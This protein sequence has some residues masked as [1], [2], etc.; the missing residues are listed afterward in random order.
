MAWSLI[1]AWDTQK[2]DVTKDQAGSVQNQT[3]RLGG[4]T[5]LAPDEDIDGYCLNTLRRKPFGRWYPRR[6]VPE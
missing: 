5:H 6:T 3:T 2:Q 1:C 4:E